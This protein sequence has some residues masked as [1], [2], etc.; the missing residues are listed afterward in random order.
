VSVRRATLDDPDWT[1][2]LLAKPVSLFGCFAMTV[3][4]SV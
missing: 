1:A 3:L 2:C 4:K